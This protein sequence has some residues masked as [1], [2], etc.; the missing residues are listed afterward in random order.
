[1]GQ[2]LQHLVESEWGATQSA[3]FDC[4]IA[5]GQY[6]LFATTQVELSMNG[7][8]SRCLEGKPQ[9]IFTIKNDIRCAMAPN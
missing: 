1:M 2:H 5:V 6:T 8:I 4:D 7:L 9:F 3:L